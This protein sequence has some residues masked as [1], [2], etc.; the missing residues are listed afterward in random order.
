M[1]KFSCPGGRIPVA[2]LVWPD[3]CSPI[4]PGQVEDAYSDCLA[5]GDTERYLVTKMS[6]YTSYASVD[7]RQFRAHGRWKAV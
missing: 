1:I 6:V 7:E 4:L 3:H 5:V 2:S